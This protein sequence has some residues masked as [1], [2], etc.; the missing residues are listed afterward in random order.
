MISLICGIQN[1]AQIA[2]STEQKH[3]HRH[4]E[5]ICGCQENRRLGEG[6]IGSLGL[7]D[8]NYFVHNG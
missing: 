6:R 3:T 8:T 2:L 5:Q 4:R 1:V 7:A